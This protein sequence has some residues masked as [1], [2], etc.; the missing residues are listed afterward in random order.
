MGDA[1]SR[2]RSFSTKRIRICEGKQRDTTARIDRMASSLEAHRWPTAQPSIWRAVAI[3]LAELRTAAPI[4]TPTQIPTAIQKAKLPANMLV[5]APMAMP[6]PIPAPIN[7]V[8][9]MAAPVI[10]K[11]RASSVRRSFDTGI[12]NRDVSRSLCHQHRTNLVNAGPRRLSDERIGACLGRS[13]L[14][15]F[16][17]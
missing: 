10:L 3:A 6:K 11:P 9:L 13:P 17:R 4:A 12:G 5:N 1:V 15:N 14:A 2:E 16:L 8:R 7:L